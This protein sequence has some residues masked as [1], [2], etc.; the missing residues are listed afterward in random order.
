MATFQYTASVDGNR[1]EGVV[2]AN[3]KQDAAAALRGQ[4]MIVLS[5]E[6]KPESRS[7]TS[8][9]G[10]GFLPSFVAA[11]LIR[12]ADVETALGQLSA[13][14]A[15]GVPIVTALNA[16]A[17]QAPRRLGRVLAAIA[18]RVRGGASLSK[19]VREEA[20]FVGETTLG[21]IAAGEANGTVAEML[22]EATH[23]MARVREV[24]SQIVQ[25]FS[26]PAIVTLGAIGVAAYMVRV[27]FPKVLKFIEGQRKGVE[28]PAVSRA[29]IAVSEFMTQYGLYVLLAPVALVVV[30]HLV[31]RT[32]Q[33]GRAI[34]RAILF[35]PLLG[36]ALRAA[37][38]AMW[39]RIL[40]TLVRSG[41]D[42]VTAIDLA[43]RTV[44]NAH[45]RAQFRQVREIV[46]RGRSLSEALRSTDLER[47]CPLAPALV[48]VGEQAGGVDTGLLQVAADS[49]ASLERRTKLL[50]KL[51]EPAVFV[52]VGG[53]VG[54][55]Y[56]GFFL[57]VLAATRSAV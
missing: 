16:L 18:A 15:G 5:L 3:S 31:R 7:A 39:A 29:L 43:E 34:D 9:A 14:L 33:G 26:Y 51:V 24:K 21:L 42:I 30:L 20:R 55:V 6:E 38:N 27:V 25:A 23:L 35:I 19:S 56:F 52:V 57:A 40:G 46:R 22:G 53:M 45:Y 10:N 37:S 1:R 4:G 44:K 36:K 8:A 54:F 11:M 49:E 13:L 50:A 2:E 12:K 48:S 28:L 17:S 32:E 47:L 41:I